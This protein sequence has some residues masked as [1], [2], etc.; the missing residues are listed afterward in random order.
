MCYPAEVFSAFVSHAFP[1]QWLHCS[2]GGMNSS[3]ARGSR[4]IAIMELAP[5]ATVRMA[6][7]HEMVVLVYRD[8][9]H[10]VC[11][12]QSSRPEFFALSFQPAYVLYD[13]LQNVKLC[14]TMFCYRFL[15]LLLLLL[16][17][18]V[19]IITI[20]II[21]VAIITLL[22]LSVI[23]LLSPLFCDCSTSLT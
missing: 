14:R 11:P 17:R 5:T 3:C 21:V 7:G 4:H 23:I 20:V 19:I 16:S 12:P 1:V 15:F 13:K 18:L 2:R 9:V 8:P 10:V 6:F 22:S